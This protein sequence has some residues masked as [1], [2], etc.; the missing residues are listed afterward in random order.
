MIVFHPRYNHPI[1]QIIDELKHFVQRRWF[2][3][4]RGCIPWSSLDPSRWRPGMEE[5]V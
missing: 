4:V 2:R 3:Q 5:E 1:P